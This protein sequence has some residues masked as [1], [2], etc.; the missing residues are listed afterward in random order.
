MNHL[1]KATDRVISIFSQIRGGI[2]KVFIF[3]DIYI[4][5][6]NVDT[7]NQNNDNNIGLLSPKTE[8]EEN[9]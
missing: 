4:D 7:G 9:K 2:H 1:P 6:R 3:H 5:N 8:D